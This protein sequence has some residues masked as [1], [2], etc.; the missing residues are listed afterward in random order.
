MQLITTDKTLVFHKIAPKNNLQSNKTCQLFT[1]NQSNGT[2]RLHA[3]Q[4]ALYNYKALSFNNFMGY[5]DTRYVFHVNL[6]GFKLGALQQL[7][8]FVCHCN[9]REHKKRSLNA[10]QYLRPRLS[11]AL[12]DLNLKIFIWKFVQFLVMQ[13]KPLFF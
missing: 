13:R 7:Q 9:F 1:S 3:V 6:I 10:E 5:C 8:K 2:D 4:K 11:T 12:R